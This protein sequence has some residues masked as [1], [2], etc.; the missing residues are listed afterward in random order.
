MLI[1]K[2]FCI[3]IILFLYKILVDGFLGIHKK[4]IDNVRAKFVKLAICMLVFDLH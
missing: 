4:R 1:Y 2:D 3:R